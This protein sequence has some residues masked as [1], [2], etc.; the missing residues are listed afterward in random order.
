MGFLKGWK[1]NS[2]KTAEP[3]TWTNEEVMPEAD[4]TEPETV[5]ESGGEEAGMDDFASELEQDD[6]I[7]TEGFSED[8]LVDDVSII[9]EG[10]DIRGDITTENSM[11]IRG[12]V[13]G[14]ISCD[15]KL[16]VAGTIDGNINSVEVYSDA[17]RIEGEIVSTGTVKIGVD[18]VIVGNI[19]AESAVIA[20][21]VKGDIDVKGTV[22]IDATAVIKGNIKSR[23]VQI[24]N[25]A[26][27]EGF[28]SQCYADVDVES[29]FEDGDKEEE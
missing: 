19:T 4:I 27:I 10:V 25:G 15:K 28:C 12:T 5:A 23:S 8:E 6:T 18:S 2:S 7:D 13:E 26:V 9:S 16:S 3:D 14:S 17:A 1:D 22:V 21:A 29:Y 20:G 24:N 11:E